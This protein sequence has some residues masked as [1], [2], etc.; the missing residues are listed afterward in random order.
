MNKL[1]NEVKQNAIQ[2]WWIEKKNAKMKGWSAENMI[3]I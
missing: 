1:T 2:S 3:Y